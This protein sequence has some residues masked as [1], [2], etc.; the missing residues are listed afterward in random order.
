MAIAIGLELK[1]KNIMEQKPRDSRKSIFAGGL[2]IR[3]LWQGIMIGILTF[4][5]YVIG[6]KMGQA[7]N[8]G[9][10]FAMHEGET[11]CFM[12]LALSQL[13]HAFNVRSESTSIFKLKINKW[14][15][16]AFVI[17][18]F[19]QLAT[20]IPGISNIFEINM[21]DFIE[22]LIIIGLSIAPVLIVELV[23]LSVNIQQK[24][25]KSKEETYIHE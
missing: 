1:E 7:K 6:F 22:W 23:K 12:V 3:I 2:A 17:C 24:K 13:F 8:L 14:L 20:T 25:K 15:V 19:L 11:M 21:P 18:L 10:E 4:L 16:G 5:A 9:D